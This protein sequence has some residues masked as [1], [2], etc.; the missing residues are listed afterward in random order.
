[1]NFDWEYKTGEIYNVPFM[2]LFFYLFYVLLEWRHRET[3]KEFFIW[4]RWNALALGSSILM[5]FA[6]TLL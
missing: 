2:A 1:M 5:A 4:D 6:A 3:W